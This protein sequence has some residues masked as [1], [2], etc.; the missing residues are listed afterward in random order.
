MAPASPSGS[1]LLQLTYVS[2]I[3]SCDKDAKKVIVERR[4]EGGVQV[5]ETQL[6]CLIT[7]LEGVNEMRRGTIDDSLRA[8]RAEVVTWSAKDA[9]IADLT[10]C[11]L[12]RLA[13]HR[14]ESVRARAALR[15][16]VL[17][18]ACKK[19]RATRPKP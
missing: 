14:Q 8:A 16:R 10:K 1:N 18:R 6:P 3:V 17:H 15:A 2:K 4:A 19:P 9:G 7:M 11:G 12:Q 13:D 5:L